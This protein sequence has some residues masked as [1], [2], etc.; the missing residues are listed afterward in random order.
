MTGFT[1]FRPVTAR[2]IVIVSTSGW[3]ARRDTVKHFHS[4]ADTISKHA[5][6]SCRTL[7]LLE[8]YAKEVHQTLY[9]YNAVFRYTW[10]RQLVQ[11]MR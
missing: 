1:R 7:H 11:W 5:V 4:S 2:A 9:R 10:F 6:S 3:R 8:I